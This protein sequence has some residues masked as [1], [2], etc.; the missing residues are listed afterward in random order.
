MTNVNSIPLIK[1]KHI[2]FKSTLF[3]S[4]ITEWNKLDSTIWYAVSFGILKSNILKFIR[5]N[6]RSFI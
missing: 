6:P 5:A 4:E 3:P 2:F 1:P